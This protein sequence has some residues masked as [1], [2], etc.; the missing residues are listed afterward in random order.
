MSKRNEKKGLNYLAI[1]SKLISLFHWKED[2]QSDFR[3]SHVLY[4]TL[5]QNKMAN[6]RKSDIQ[7][8][9]GKNDLG[10]N[11]SGKFLTMGT[12]D[13][14][15]KK[16]P[17]VKQIWPIIWGLSYGTEIAVGKNSRF[18]R[19]I[20]SMIDPK[21]NSA[22]I[23]CDPVDHVMFQIWNLSASCSFHRSV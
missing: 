21:W 7:K 9:L 13:S 1:I 18:G 15:W 11:W 22:K 14:R 12:F 16:Y 8:I 19:L 20:C 10:K 6:F 23:F 17:G 3:N 4:L 2:A 5:S